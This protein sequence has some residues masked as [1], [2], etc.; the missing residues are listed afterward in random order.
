M[1]IFADRFHFFK[2]NPFHW[3]MFGPAYHQQKHDNYEQRLKKWTFDQAHEK[4][5]QKCLV[6]SISC[7]S[8]QGAYN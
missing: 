8:F 5:G 1:F 3:Y 7:F 4:F 6:F 2:K